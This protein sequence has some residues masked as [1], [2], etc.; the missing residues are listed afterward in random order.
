M[1]HILAL[2]QGTSSSRAIVFGSD[3]HHAA[4]VQKPLT[5][6]FPQPGWVEQNPYDI[7]ATQFE[8]AKEALKNAGIS[9][10]NLAAIG[11][12]N[13]RET[14]MLWSKRTGHP[15]SHAIVW[16]DRRTT[17]WCEAQRAA[18]LD[19]IVRAKT[20]L[21]L[22]PYFSASKIVWLLDNIPGARQ[23]AENGELLF[24]T[25]DSWLIWQLT[26]GE[27][28]LTD[29]TNASRTMLYNIHD[30]VWDADL[31]QRWKIPAAILPTVQ[32][33]GSHFGATA[34]FGSTVPITGVAGDQQAALFGQD[35]ALPGQAKNTYGTGCF[36]M[37]HTGDNAYPSKQGLLTT[38]ALQVSRQEQ[39]ALEGAAF[40]TGSLVQWLRDGLGIISHAAEIETLAA[41]VPHADQVMIVPAFNGLGSP[42]WDPKARGTIVGITGGTTRA[43]LAR[44]AL[45]SIALQ[46]AELV[47]A[48]QSDTQLVMKELYVDGGGAV[49]DLLMQMQAD[50][51]G[52]PVLRPKNVE[53]TAFGVAALAARS[54]GVFQYAQDKD[55]EIDRFEPQLSRDAAASK[56]ALWRKA[57]ERSKQWV[58]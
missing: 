26:A 54:I 9:G 27:K 28:H 22:D 1:A 33:S 43:H 57:V 11:L 31:L 36:L 45:Q 10:Q 44:A 37:M 47:D 30:G 6:F 42:H 58:E 48:M 8:C 21:R 51:L 5:S 12:T 39:F 32:I 46:V 24:G 34:L 14:T 3:G 50:Y 56:L 2:D 41:S 16:Q 53:T 20:G 7:W 17:P 35:C 40:N 13:Q 15:V 18:G 49:N 25:V 4:V 23:L 55:V 29:I 52:V 38:R 19:S